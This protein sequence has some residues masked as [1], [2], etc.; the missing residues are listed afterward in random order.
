MAIDKLSINDLLIDNILGAPPP[1]DTFNAEPIDAQQPDLTCTPDQT[2]T[3]AHWQVV[4][5]ENAEG[6]A[7]GKATGLY[8]KHRRY[9]KQWN[10]WNPVRSAH[11]FQLA[12]SLRQQTKTWISQHLRCGLGT[13]KMG[14]FQSANA[15][16]AL[17]SELDFGLRDDSWIE[18]ESHI[19]ST[20]YH[21][22]V[23]KC[24][25]FLLAHLPF[26][27]QLDFELVRL[28][29]LRVIESTAR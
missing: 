15:L 23:F 18:D 22:D 26:Q 8:N 4:A 16:R 19:F 29:S 1:A 27:A 25:P 3:Q 14:S 13:F 17:L 12:Q 6:K 20:L 9:S 10:P 2:K 11:D 21:R 5:V 7:Y 24:I 28:M